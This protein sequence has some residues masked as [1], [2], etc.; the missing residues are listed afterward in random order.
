MNTV[1]SYYS[2]G[3]FP[4]PFS[5]VDFLRAERINYLSCSVE[6]TAPC[7][8]SLSI[9]TPPHLGAGP[10]LSALSPPGLTS[11][12]TQVASLIHLFQATLATKWLSL[13]ATRS[14]TGS[15]WATR[16]QT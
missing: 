7:I 9:A 2:V 4:F 8:A 12:R 11:D 16:A 14:W 3:V 1:I 5:S 6:V 13:R 15:D 10:A